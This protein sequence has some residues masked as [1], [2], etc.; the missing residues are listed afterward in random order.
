MAAF[1]AQLDAEGIAQFATRK[2]CDKRRYYTEVTGIPVIAKDH[3]FA[4]I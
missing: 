4:L 1:P 3:G 2:A